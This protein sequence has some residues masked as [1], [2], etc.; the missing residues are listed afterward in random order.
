MSM[1]ETVR[2]DMMAAMKA[3]DSTRKEILSELLSALKSKHIDK[4]ADL[5]PEEELAVVAREVKQAK[6][7]LEMTPADRTE[8]IE[9]AEAKINVLSEML[10][11]QMD[12]AA[13]RA[14]IEAVLLSLGLEKPAPG[15][16]GRIMKELMP[17]VKGKADGKL[18][19]EL[20][21]TYFA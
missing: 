18:V 10:P 9:K 16:K 2:A 17:R 15:D 13:I 1:I 8:L 14:E 21:A 19:N 4:R 6:E 11:K 20:L 7:T 12:E 5:T 3:H